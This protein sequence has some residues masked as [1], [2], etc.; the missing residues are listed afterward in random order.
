MWDVPRAEVLGM[1]ILGILLIL[2]GLVLWVSPQIPYTKRNT[3]SVTPSTE[4]TSKEER[5]AV[6]PHPVA[7][8][9]AGAGI[10]VLVLAGIGRRA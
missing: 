4:I 2:L 5:M 10:L 3:V 8:L 1:R 9:I 7:A 6:V